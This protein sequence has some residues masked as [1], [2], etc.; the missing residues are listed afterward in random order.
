M[1]DEAARFTAEQT[2]MDAN[3]EIREL[4]HLLV[5]AEDKIADLELEIVRLKGTSK[6]E[7]PLASV[8]SEK[9]NKFGSDA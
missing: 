5:K 9:Y 7:E 2:V 4:K 8:M 1:T 6:A 3:I